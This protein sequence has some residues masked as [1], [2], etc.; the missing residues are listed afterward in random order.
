MREFDDFISRENKISKELRENRAFRELFDILL[1]E[2]N[3]IA[4]VEAC[5]SDTPPI[6]ACAEVIDNYVDLFSDGQLDLND[7]H[8]K[9]SVGKIAKYIVAPFGYTPAGKRLFPKN[10]KSK[11]LTSGSIYELTETP[12]LKLVVVKEIVPAR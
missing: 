9:Q 10:A 5:E 12:E 1:R 8:T 2:E 7:Y 6:L 11:Y 3:Q 4:M